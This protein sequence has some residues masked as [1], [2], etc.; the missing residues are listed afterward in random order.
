MSRTVL[1]V[2]ANH[3]LTGVALRVLGRHRQPA[4]IFN[5]DDTPPA[6]SR[7]RA[8]VINPDAPDLGDAI[9]EAARAVGATH[10]IPDEVA[11]FAAV[12]DVTEALAPAVAFPSCSAADIMRFDSK[13]ELAAL[14][15][16][17]GL[18]VV[19]THVVHSANDAP[20]H[21][22]DYPILVKPDG[23]AAGAGQRRCDQPADLL[24]LLPKWPKGRQLI[25]P[26]IPGSDVHLSFVADRGELIGWEIR[27]PIP[28]EHPTPGMFRVIEDDEALD[29]AQRLAIGTAYHGLGNLDF[30][31]DARTGR[32]GLLE[33]N[34]RL[35]ATMDV[36]ARAGADLLALGLDLADGR[37][38]D[39][40]VVAR[41]GLVHTGRGLRTSLSSRPPARMCWAALRASAVALADIQLTIDM[42][43]LSGR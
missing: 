20:T 15:T 13:A 12:A 14:A 31:R 11:M 35:Y 8:G 18:P 40:P 21:P 41:P 3:R 34:P 43:S 30:R 9:V 1:L 28:V 42:S 32:L 7:W 24:A 16:S 36:A 23:A 4:W 5:P 38:P 19:P 27:E 33:C 22:F 6:R 2:S 29:I 25:Q 39:K 10:V 17:L 37:R 26:L